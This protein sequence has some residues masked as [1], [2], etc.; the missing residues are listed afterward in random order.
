[1][2]PDRPAYVKDVDTEKK[3]PEVIDHTAFG[4]DLAV[5]P[6]EGTKRYRIRILGGGQLSSKLSGEYTRHDLAV[7]AIEEYREERQA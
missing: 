6:I 4:R 7:R 5:E 3:E 1:M 2:E